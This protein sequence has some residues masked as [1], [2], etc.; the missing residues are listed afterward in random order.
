M[1]GQTEG[2]RLSWLWLHNALGFKH[3]YFLCMGITGSNSKLSSLELSEI[4][5]QTYD[6]NSLDSYIIR[7]DEKRSEDELSEMNSMI[8]NDS[9]TVKSYLT[10]PKDND[11]INNI[12]I[13][14]YYY[15]HFNYE[16][17]FII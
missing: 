5:S 13:N 10:N 15:L 11:N 3:V 17:H 9:L 7:G 4:R 6:N 2:R 16:K 14:Y 8:V 1:V 12:D